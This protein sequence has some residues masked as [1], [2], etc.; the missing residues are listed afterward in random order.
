MVR[1][2]VLLAGLGASASPLLAQT[3]V[4]KAASHSDAWMGDVKAPRIVR[5]PDPPKTP[6]PAPYWKAAG[7]LALTDVSGNRT[8]SLLTTGLRAQLAGNPDFELSLAASVRYGRSDGAVAAESYDAS[9]DM[10]LQPARTISPYINLKGNRDRIRGV[11][12]RVAAAAGADVNLY[13][14]DDQR[15]S[16]G[17]ALLQ[18]YETRDLPAG[19]PEEA[20]VSLTRLNVRAFLSTDLR[21]GIR[22]EHRSLIEPAANRFG[23]YLFTSAT[24][25]RFDL[26]SR[27]AFQTAYTY[28]RDAT[29]PPGVQFKDDRTLT[30]GVVVEMGRQS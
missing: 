27:L 24:S 4:S 18:D 16:L 25:L 19:S 29:P 20:S 22:C 28:N 9:A 21:P 12:L 10:R 8:L 23:D 2:L 1:F 14:H 30:V 15:F 11:I 7:E 13:V 3:G 17:V 26:T 5:P 6:S